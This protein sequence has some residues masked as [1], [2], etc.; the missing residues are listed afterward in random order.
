MTPPLPLIN[1]DVLVRLA[2]RHAA[3]R[4]AHAYL[5]T[6][7]AGSGTFETALALAQAVNC[8]E[9]GAR[10]GECSCPSCRR[11]RDGNHPDIFII[12]KPEDKTEIVIG[13]ITPKTGEAYRSLLPWLSVRALEAE[14]RVVI[15]READRLSR[16]AA[17]AFLKTLEEPCAGTLFILTSAAAGNIPPT[18]VS[19]CQEV[20]FL[21]P[22]RTPA[23][24]NI[25]QDQVNAII[26][27]FIAGPGSEALLKKWSADKA[28]AAVLLNVV[29]VFYRDVLCV[30]NGVGAQALYSGGRVAAVQAAAARM[31]ANDAHAVIRQAV[32]SLEAVGANFNVKA[33]LTLLKEIMDQGAYG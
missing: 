6:G 21:T 23:F 22:G 17:N 10:A 13:Q 14:V 25:A 7:P 15:I 4:L 19:R 11:I 2:A 8:R 20:R 18:V 12:E 28:Q 3:G 24:G 5:F 30:Q 31:T 9:P 27:E 1:H 32:R 16:S 33:A 26:D 29:L